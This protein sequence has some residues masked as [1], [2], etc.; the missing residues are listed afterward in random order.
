MK[1]DDIEDVLLKGRS[2]TDDHF[3][4]RTVDL[5]VD[6][7]NAA[8]IAAIARQKEVAYKAATKFIDDVQPL[9]SGPMMKAMSR[10]RHIC[11]STTAEVL[12]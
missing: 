2:A 11:F 3:W 7:V 12:K 8:E 1:R 9:V 4:T 6:I 10:I 5:V